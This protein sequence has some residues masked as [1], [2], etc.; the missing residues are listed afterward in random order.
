MT[1]D[2]IPAFAGMTSYIAFVPEAI[3]IY[4]VPSKARLTANNTGYVKI[5]D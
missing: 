3:S 4:P 1:T 2:W 5:D